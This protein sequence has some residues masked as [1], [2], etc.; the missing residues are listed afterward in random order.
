[1]FRC[2]TNDHIGFS[3]CIIWTDC[4]DI[5][6]AVDDSAS[7]KFFKLCHDGEKY[8]LAFDFL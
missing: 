6:A 5:L 4:N 7:K 8:P 2:E 1:M 3:L